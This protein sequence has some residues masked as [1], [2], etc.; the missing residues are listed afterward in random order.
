[1][2]IKTISISCLLLLQLSFY[3]YQNDLSEE[4]VRGNRTIF[5]IGNSLTWDTVPTLLDEDVQYHVD[6]GKSLPYIFKNPN[7]PCVDSSL[8]WTKALNENTFDIIS[9][10]P[11]YGSTFHEDIDVISMWLKMQPQA[12]V[13]IHEGWAKQSSRKE[14]Y[15]TSILQNG[16]FHGSIYYNRLIDTLSVTFPETKFRRTYTTELLERISKD[17]SDGNAPYSELSELYRDDIHM[18]YQDG[19]YLM[20]NAMRIAIDQDI[21]DVGFNEIIEE[22]QSYLNGI[23]SWLK[24][25]SE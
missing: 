5:L 16:M 23:L 7:D 21:S 8:I 3:D 14:E 2:M 22:N 17:I 13:I 9:F 1:M 15:A 10:Q 4:E 11:H 12:D 24:K 20:H 6:C 19:R 25:N 18:T